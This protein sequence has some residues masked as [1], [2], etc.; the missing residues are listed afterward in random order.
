MWQPKQNIQPIVK[1]ICTQECIS[2]FKSS[3][4]CHISFKFLKEKKLIASIKMQL[5]HCAERD[6]INLKSNQL[7][8]ERKEISGTVLKSNSPPLVLAKVN[9]FCFVFLIFSSLD[10][11][12]STTNNKGKMIKNL[13]RQGKKKGNIAI[14]INRKQQ[15]F[16]SS[17]PLT[18]R[19]H[20][21]R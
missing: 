3:T 9:Q 17:P 11:L 13:I 5:G 19:Y 2:L 12:F 4:E 7:K 21:I 14:D 18:S 6:I 1:W 15:Y 10:F 20:L 8:T 16:F